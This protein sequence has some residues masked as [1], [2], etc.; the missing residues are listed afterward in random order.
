MK[1]LLSPRGL[2]QLPTQFADRILG[3]FQLGLS[4]VRTFPLI[5]LSLLAG[6]LQIFGMVFAGK[7]CLFQHLF[8]E[9]Q[10]PI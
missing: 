5:G 1:R 3:L 10:E 4:F 7:P 8:D 6:V 2:P 9:Q